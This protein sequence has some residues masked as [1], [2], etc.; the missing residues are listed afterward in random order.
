MDKSKFK[1]NKIIVILLLALLLRLITVD[2][3]LWLD[4]AIGAL[5]VK[6]FNYYNLI[7]KFM[8][9]DNHSPLYYILLKFWTGFFGF[10]E[11]GIRSLTIFA[12][13]VA[14]YLSFKL[15]LLLFKN[16]Y[17]AMF[18]ALFLA[19]SQFY[20]YYTQEARMYALTSLFSVA[21]IYY[22]LKKNWVCYSIFITAL[23]FTDYVPVFFLPVVFIF[24]FLD[25]KNRKDWK[26]FLLS[27]IPMVVLGLLW[28]PVFLQQLQNG[29]V[30]LTIF[31]QWK[32]VAGGASLKN[33]ILVWTKFTLGRISFA[34]KL[35]Y[36][37]T[38]V[39]SSLIYLIVL[40]KSYKKQLRLVFLFVSPL[41]ITFLASIFF[42]AFNYFRFTYLYPFFAIILAKSLSNFSKN[43]Q[44][45]LSLLLILINVFS[46]SVY[47][48]DQNQ[49][50]E[51]WKQSI[52]FL[53]EV[54]PKDSLVL[55]DFSA[56]VAPYNWYNTGK[57]SAH[58]AT[59]SIS[60]D[61]IETVNRTIEL[62]NDHKLVYYFEYLRDLSDPGHL[63]EKT[64]A[65]QGFKVTKVYGQFKGGVGQIFVWEKQ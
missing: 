55:F 26:V 20:V 2:Q 13:I 8:P 51:Q 21:A 35:F 18:V 43:K 63:V 1:V 10:S 41:I 15:S 31:P 53:E 4:E 29:S 50:R 52:S 36:Y 64:L 37:S 3:S 65:S 9:A 46:L 24:F 42:P 27:H 23:I 19:T 40:S 58:G 5:A 48:S 32:T 54:A 62:V 57:L 56:P 7:Y 45:I 39:F 17:Q 6:N 16:K 14:I 49:Q 30:A 33:A 28:L 60:A 44:L 12:S 38:L 25:T 22:L 11:L 59:N 47:Y 34:D 61:E